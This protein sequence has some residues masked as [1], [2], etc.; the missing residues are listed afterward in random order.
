MPVFS[1]LVL[2]EIPKAKVKVDEVAW[3]VG[4]SSVECPQFP[5]RQTLLARRSPS[6]CDPAVEA[7]YKAYCAAINTF[8]II[9]LKGSIK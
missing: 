5:R 2:L 9:V 1:A 7:L 4:T 3:H 8:E 6:Y